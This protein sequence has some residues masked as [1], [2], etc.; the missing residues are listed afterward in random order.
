MFRSSVCRPDADAK[1][2]TA[3]VGAVRDRLSTPRLWRR[4]ARLF[5]SYLPESIGRAQDSICL[6]IHKATFHLCWN[7]GADDHFGRTTAINLQQ[8]SIHGPEGQMLFVLSLDQKMGKG[9]SAKFA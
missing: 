4:A 6:L 1:I 5:W 8:L 9:C 3:G 2:K 7:S